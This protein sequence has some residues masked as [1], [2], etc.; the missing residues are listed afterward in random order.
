MEESRLLGPLEV[1]EA[2]AD[3]ADALDKMKSAVMKKK[4]I[5]SQRN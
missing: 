5:H 2:H 3:I 1:H 4:R